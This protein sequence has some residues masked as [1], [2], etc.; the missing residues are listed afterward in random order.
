MRIAFLVGQFPA[1]SETFVL[2]QVTGLID[3]GHEI[4]I[5]ATAPGD[6]DVVHGEVAKYGL[7][8]RTLYHS[9]DARDGP[10]Q[11]AVCLIQNRRRI[12]NLL[13]KRPGLLFTAPRLALSPM[14]WR[15]SQLMNG[16]RRNY[17]VIQCHFGPNGRLAVLLRELDIVRGPIVTA[18][19]G[20]DLSLYLRRHGASVYRRLFQCGDLFLPISACWQSKLIELG[21]PRQ[22]ILVHRMGIEL[23]R[24]AC[25]ERSLRPNGAIKIVTI[26]RLVE[27]KGIGYGIQAVS[28]LVR[29][30]PQ[31]EYR[32]I[33]DG[34]LKDKLQGLIR[35]LGVAEQVK[36][37][38]WK[39]RE[40]IRGLL[41][42][43]DILLAPSVTSDDGD[44]E[45][46][47]VVLMEAAAYGRPVVSTRHSGISE[48]VR[49]GESGY[50]VPE[51][52]ARALAEKLAYL[53]EH[54]N[55]RAAMGAAGR[56][57]VETHYDIRKLNEQL[58]RIYEGLKLAIPA[59]RAKAELY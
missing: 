22:K 4:D 12:G 41:Q 5:Y 59:G 36:L 6:G 9:T 15:K 32:I 8:G 27:K 30:W 26:G 44:E 18:F 47:P 34:R 17:D 51:R 43:S 53:V 25:A 16:S 33:G 31:I 2:N 46:I 42:E 19:H 23:Q 56:K 52:D 14:L 50:L 38:G 48:A 13:R 10:V 24:Y 3:R 57:Q 45:G 54:P 29:R 1:I 40:E 58:E 28:Q 20:W 21:C 7:L 37:L 49:D 35:D 39:S 55:T 11:K